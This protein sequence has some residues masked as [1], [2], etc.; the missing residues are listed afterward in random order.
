[1]ALRS[2]PSDGPCG[3]PR[4]RG[5]LEAH[6]VGEAP[7]GASTRPHSLASQTSSWPA[8]FVCVGL[9]GS[10]RSSLVAMAQI[11]GMLVPE[12]EGGVGQSH[13]S[14]MRRRMHRP[15]LPWSGQAGDARPT[16]RPSR[17]LL[18]GVLASL[19]LLLP[20]HFISRSHPSHSLSSRSSP[21][22]HHHTTPTR[23]SQ[24]RH[25]IPTRLRPPPARA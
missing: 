16:H 9:F 11:C 12:S 15:P 21:S 20:I 7:S 1:M 13:T 8:S 6:A 18:A 4:P 10:C 22:G 23:T 24:P 3:Q 19:Q 17:R 2:A 14:E 5:R 25:P